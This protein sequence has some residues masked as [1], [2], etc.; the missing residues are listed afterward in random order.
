MKPIPTLIIKDNH[1]VAP[2]RPAGKSLQRVLAGAAVITLAGLGGYWLGQTARTPEPRKSHV[3]TM[4]VPT[5][6]AISTL[7][8]A[9][10]DAL[11]DAVPTT[12]AD[13][14]RFVQA[15]QTYLQQKPE[16][17]EALKARIDRLRADPQALEEHNRNVLNRVSIPALPD[18]TGAN[19]ARAVAAS[20]QTAGQTQDDSLAA[21]QTEA[22]QREAAG[23][24][25]V[26]RAG[27]TLWSIS[28]RV[29]GDPHQFRRLYEANPRVLASPDHIYPGQVLRVPS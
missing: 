2:S 8:S 25:Y 7:Q 28:G 12:D 29:Y 18:D 13:E 27:D 20:A 14:R 3:D 6:V 15:Q 22:S 10:N 26:V 19:I 1:I 23:Q 24:T 4:P 11:L 9:V 21:L 5:P 17:P 16:T